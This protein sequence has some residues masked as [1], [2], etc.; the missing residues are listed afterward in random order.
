MT[1][2]TQDGAPSALLVE[3]EQGIGGQ[4]GRHRRHVKPVTG[5]PWL[6]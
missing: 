4:A 3:Q 2:G 5:A 1:E 6:L